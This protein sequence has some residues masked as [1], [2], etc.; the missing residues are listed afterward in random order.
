MKGQALNGLKVIDLSWHIAGPYCTKLM[1]DLGAQ[2]IKIERPE[3]GDPS[4]QEGPF[5][6]DK[7]N[8]NASALYGYLNNNKQ[9]I[10]LNLKTER[11]LEIIKKLI[12]DAD[13]LVENFSPKVMTGL[14]LGYE[15]LK[16][17]NPRLVMTSIS[18]FG[19]TGK[20]RDYEATELITQAMSG[21]I[22]SIG[23]PEREPLRAGGALRMMEYITGAFAAM[24]TMAAVADRRR[25]GEGKH[26][27]VSITECGLLQRS[28]PTV[29]NSFPTSP[30]KHTQRYVMMPSIEKCKDGYIGINLLTGKHWQDFC[31]MTEMYDWIDDPR[32]TTLFYRL[33]HK[34]IF[35]ERFDKWLMQ[36]TR[37]EIIQLGAEWRVPVNPV[38][39]FEE[40]IS[41]PQY[42]EREFFVEVDHP[43]MGKVLQPGA[44]FHMSE[45]PW[46]INSP[47]PLLG[48]HNSRV[49][50]DELG[51]SETELQILQAERVI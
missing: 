31:L 37:E 45:T 47:A 1:A 5:P 19:Q 13:I 12:C 29:Q 27:D 38:P 8:L 4:R 44:P 6:N 46:K 32:F 14:G 20:Y 26:V 25:S 51:I 10:T 28:Y 18:N 16:K 22:S 50:G 17:I 21:F 33:Q 2:V 41:F 11:G 43:V 3:L 9:G 42:K 49:L 23:E 34:E 48:E 40:M 7:P 39:T 35:R 15:E 30:S 24:S 36:H